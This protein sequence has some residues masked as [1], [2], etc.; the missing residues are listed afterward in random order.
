[1][2]KAEPLMAVSTVE[3]QAQ[4][5]LSNA[6]VT[7]TATTDTTSR[8]VTPEQRKRRLDD[9]RKS[10]QKDKTLDVNRARRDVS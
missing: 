2:S 3:P 8:V 5:K 9:L 10:S 4:D 7:T 6:E 1:V